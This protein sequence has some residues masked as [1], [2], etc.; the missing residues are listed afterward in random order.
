MCQNTQ[1]PAKVAKS[2]IRSHPCL[3]N[4]RVKHAQVERLVGIL[5][6]KLSAESTDPAGSDAENETGVDL[7]A[8]DDLQKVDEDTLQRVKGAM[9]Q[10]FEK[11]FIGK[12]HPDFQ[13][14]RR[15]EFGE[16]EESND[17][18]VESGEEEESGAAAN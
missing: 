10:D 3:S 15:V 18:D 2:L 8:V 12:D 6:Q 7:T 16:A 11:N 17:W 14:D 1:D 5:I 4:P 9:N 13:Y